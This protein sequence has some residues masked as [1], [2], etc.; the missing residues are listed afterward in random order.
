MVFQVWYCMS[1]IT[2]KNLQMLVDCLN[3]ITKSPVSTYTKQKNGKHT[4]NLKNYHLSYAY[5]GVCL[6]RI[7]S[8]GG[9]V[10]DVF[11]CGHITKK[12][13]WDRIQAYK[14]GLSE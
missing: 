6:H 8:I 9:G 4:A 14:I 13:L 5:G 11:S 7:C 10:E 1:R 3:N 12:Q 2:E